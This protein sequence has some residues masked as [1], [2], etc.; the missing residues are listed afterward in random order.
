MTY[1]ECNILGTILMDKRLMVAIKSDMALEK[2]L[3]DAVEAARQTMASTEVAN[4]S[5]NVGKIATI[6]RLIS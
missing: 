2:N 5:I 4:E 3:E 1:T 6:L